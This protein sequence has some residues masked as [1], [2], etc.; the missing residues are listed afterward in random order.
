MVIFENNPLSLSD[1]SGHSSSSM[2]P[3]YKR[4]FA[5]NTVYYANTLLLLQTLIDAQ[6]SL[7]LYLFFL[8]IT[9]TFL[10]TKDLSILYIHLKKSVKFLLLALPFSCTHG[11][12]KILYYN[13]HDLVAAGSKLSDHKGRPNPAQDNCDGASVDICPDLVLAAFAAA[14]AAAFAVIF[15]LVTALGRK[16]KRSADTFEP[17]TLTN[18]VKDIYWN[19]GK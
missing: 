19:L 15:T 10:H 12:K 4:F 14:A 18:V 9:Y 13:S 6:V 2:M 11:T 3:T 7:L 1:S 16:K 17:V 5:A 8:L